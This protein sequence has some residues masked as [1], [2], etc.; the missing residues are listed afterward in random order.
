MQNTLGNDLSLRH[1]PD[2][3]DSSFS[4]EIPPGSNDEFLLDHDDDFLGAAGDSFTT[5]ASN[6]TIRQPLTKSR[7]IPKAFTQENSDSRN[8]TSPE[9]KIVL[10]DSSHSNSAQPPNI[11]A[12]A[13]KTI[14]TKSTAIRKLRTGVSLRD[15]VMSTPQRIQRLRDEIK[16]LAESKSSSA[17]TVPSSTRSI[18]IPKNDHR[19]NLDPKA[20]DSGEDSAPPHSIPASTEPPPVSPEVNQTVRNQV[21]SLESENNDMNVSSSNDLA[22]RLLM[23][24]QN[25]VRSHVLSNSAEDDSVASAFMGSSSHQGQLSNRATDDSSKT[26]ETANDMPLTFSQLSPSK[27]EEQTSIP[28]GTRSHSDVPPSP[29]RQSHKRQGSPFPDARLG[30]KDKTPAVISSSRAALSGRRLVVKKRTASS[31]NSSSVTS[32]MRSKPVTRS[33]MSSRNQLYVPQDRSGSSGASS[34]E[35]G[36]LSGASTGSL[37]SSGGSSKVI[38][39]RSE[40]STQVSSTSMPICIPS[41]RFWFQLSRNRPTRSDGFKFQSDMRIEARKTDSIVR[42]HEEKP[43]KKQKLHTAYTVPN[44]EAS[45]S[46]QDVLLTSLK[47]HIRP[48]FPLPVEMHTDARARERSKFDELVRE[49]ELQA[50]RAMEEKKRQQAEEE[51]REIKE[52]RKKAIPKAHPVPE[53]YK[54]APRR[55]EQRP[56]SRSG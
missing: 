45:R 30:E 1:L 35:Q 5:P 18:Y 40:G 42:N 11:S 46:A 4:F 23:Y 51:K 53:W 44:F 25:S 26:S 17:T 31:V 41:S 9:K 34:M 52:Q 33:T 29:M 16:G 54:D 32:Q 13:S 38:L 2:L 20:A 55:K 10:S 22:G 21:C 37:T 49:K 3:S 27:T 28:P 12:E 6:R 19:L 56:Y 48:V 39:D 14:R 50:S 36:K 8:R 24:N 43:R 15:D 7:S 47:D